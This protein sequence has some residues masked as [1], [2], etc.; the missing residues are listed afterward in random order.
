MDDLMG[1]V[2]D[3]L[4]PYRLKYFGETPYFD[5]LVHWLPLLCTAVL[6]VLCLPFVAFGMCGVD[7]E[8]SAKGHTFGKRFVITAI[9]SS[10]RMG[11]DSR[12]AHLR[13]RF[14]PGSSMPSAKKET[15]HMG[16]PIKGRDVERGSPGSGSKR[17]GVSRFY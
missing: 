11:K 14:H 16:R 17:S 9:R 3:V 4:D 15:D 10:V 12:L 8:G 6:P 5:L 2:V 7:D 13:K 1:P